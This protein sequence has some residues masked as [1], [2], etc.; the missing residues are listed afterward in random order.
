MRSAQGQISRCH[1][2]RKGPQGPTSLPTRSV[3]QPAILEVDG[4]SWLR[5]R[6]EAAEQRRKRHLRG[7]IPGFLCQRYDDRVHIEPMT[8]ADH[9]EVSAL[10]RAC[11]HWLSD[12]DGFTDQQREFL[13]GPRSAPETLREESRT[14]PHL[15]ARDQDGSILGMAAVRENEIARLYVHPAYHGRGV[16][17]ALFEAAESLISAAG[18]TQITVA[19]LV[20][21]AA[22]F[23]RARGMHEVGRQPYEPQIF[24]GREVVLLAKT[25]AKHGR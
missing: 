25:A 14:R 11:F 19:A 5:G 6:P 7:H 18:H 15:V 22:A 10:L 9:A 12:R 2:P 20:E 8:D 3:L 4:S 24:G 16:G 13:V 1:A 23:Y 21:S 17:Q